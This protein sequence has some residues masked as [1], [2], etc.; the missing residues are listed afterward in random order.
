MAGMSTAIQVRDELSPAMGVMAESV[1]HLRIIFLA[2]QVTAEQ[3]VEVPGIDAATGAMNEMES[4]AAEVNTETNNAAEGQ[5]EFS[6]EVCA[7]AGFVDVLLGKMK[8]L[9]G[10]IFSMDRVKEAFSM[11]DEMADTMAG[12]EAINDGQQTT[13]ELFQ[14]VA[15]SANNARTD[16]GSMA[17]AVTDFGRNAKD[18]FSSTGEMVDFANLMS[19]S[20]EIAGMSTEDSA[21]SMSQ[22]SQALAM[23]AQGGEELNSIFQQAPNLIGYLSEYMDMPIEK[24][25]EMAFQGEISAET[26]KAAVFAASGEINGE[27]E[28]LPTTFGQI[29]AMMG[30]DFAVAF[31]PAFEKLSEFAS[32]EEMQTVMEGAKDVLE[33]LGAVASEV[34]GIMESAVGFMIENWDIIGSLILGAAIAFGICAIA[35]GIVTIAQTIFNVALWTCPLT[36]I[37]LGIIAIIGIIA[38]VV[39]IYNVWTGSSISTFGVIC[40]CINVVIQFFC[41]LALLAP[42]VAEIASTAFM[43]LLYN[44]YVSYFNIGQTIKAFFFTIV[45]DGIN[46]VAKLCA[47]LN[48]L[49]FISF[50]YSG[51]EAAANTFAL[52]AADASNLKLSYVDIG[53]AVKNI[54]Q[55]SGAFKDGWVSDAYKNGYDWG[56]GFGKNK[57][58]G[59]SD[60]SYAYEPSEGAGTSTSGAG[61]MGATADNTGATAGNT[62]RTAENTAAIANSVDI[63]NEQLKYLRDIAERDT[64]NRFTTASIKVTMNNNNTVNSEMDLDGIVNDLAYSVENAMVM[65]AEG[66]HK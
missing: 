9:A 57:G 20:M 23:G 22:L 2:F 27:F 46:M 15:A 4:A 50:D 48:K 47:A 49:P 45:S 51:I 53:A 58:D 17:S 16:M 56:A 7:G 18:A 11:S 32:S 65:A 63:S 26:L 66:V 28:Q 36:W 54:F 12:F 25:R 24:I 43:M 6:N 30:N 21:A 39:E 59:K 37:V 61:N 33:G 1:E 14:A 62:G 35:I 55:S 52:K 8:S 5:K 60:N 42:A 40:G 10:S 64:V 13:Q 38:R 34:I 41:N 44:A 19:K 3:Y 31:A 29:A